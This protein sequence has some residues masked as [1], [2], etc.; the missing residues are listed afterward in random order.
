VE[1]TEIL[2]HAAL[3]GIWGSEFRPS[4]LDGKHF[5]SLPPPSNFHKV[6]LPPPWYLAKH[7]QLHREFSSPFLGK[8][9]STLHCVHIKLHFHTLTDRI[10]IVT[11]SQ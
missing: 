1:V 3:C 10:I 4:H 8:K 6:I 11:S 2:P 7:Y 9:Y 5:V